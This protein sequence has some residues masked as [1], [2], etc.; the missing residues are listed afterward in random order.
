MEQDT[1]SEKVPKGE[2]QCV[3]VGGVKAEAQRPQ[4]IQ[5]EAGK[6]PPPLSPEALQC[7]IYQWWQRKQCV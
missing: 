5:G 6:Q 3:C 7:F 1:G 4:C 2:N